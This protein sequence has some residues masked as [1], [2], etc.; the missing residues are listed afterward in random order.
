LVREFGV[1]GNS[2][3]VLVLGLIE[4]DWSPLSDLSLCDNLANVAG[5]V[6]GCIEETWIPCARNTRVSAQPSWE[7]AARYFGIDVRSRSL[8][9]D[10]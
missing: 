10:Q 5:I 1:T 3:T 6:I 2:L 7:A 9:S 8:Y 4:D